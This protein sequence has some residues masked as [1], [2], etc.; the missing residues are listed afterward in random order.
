MTYDRLDSA[1]LQWPCP[2]EDHPGT[3][4]L[5]RDEFV[6]GVRATLRDVEYHETPEAISREYPFRLITGRSLYQFNAGTM[7]GR[8]PNNDLR[9]SDVLDLSS[10]DAEVLDIQD[11]DM[12]RVSSRYGSA[13]LAAHVDARLRSGDL[14]A[15]FHQPTT[16][17]NTLT[18]SNRDTM[19]GTPEYKVTAVR[20]EPSPSTAA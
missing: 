4:L 18:S 6:I 2:G 12:I 5:H 16:L 17:L 10:S 14:F 15:T 19:V 11:G 8:T 7:T 13:H 9:P 20:I 3:S 1:G